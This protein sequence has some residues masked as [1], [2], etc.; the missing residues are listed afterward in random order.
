MFRVLNCQ[1]DVR[2]GL[3]FIHRFAD[4]VEEIG[5]N[6][7]AETTRHQIVFHTLRHTFASWLALAGTDISHIKTLMQHKTITMTMRYTHLIPVATRAAVHSLRPSSDV[8]GAEAK[9]RRE[10]QE[11][12][13]KHNLPKFANA[14]GVSRVGMP[15]RFQNTHSHPACLSGQRENQISTMSNDAGKTPL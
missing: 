5:F 7:H 2:D 8:K 6:K 4:P 1:Q 3:R 10:Q 14:K 12:A 13:S 15:S 9:K 11:K